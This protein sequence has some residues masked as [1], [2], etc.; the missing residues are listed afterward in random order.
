MKLVFFLGLY[1][2]MM[3]CLWW[4]IVTSTSDEWMPPMDYVWVATDIYEKDLWTQ[5][6]FSLYHSVLMLT[7]NDLGPRGNLQVLFIASAVTLGAIINAVL[8]G[9]LAMIVSTMNVRNAKFLEKLEM[10]QTAMRNIEL[11]SDMQFQIQQYL[12]FS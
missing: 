6:L 8:F 11:P 10:A 12:G 7:G 2:H 5:Y 9:E 1:L 4:F 3:G